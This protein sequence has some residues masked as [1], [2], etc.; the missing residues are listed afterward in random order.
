[1]NQRSVSL[2]HTR[3]DSD[4][5]LLFELYKNHEVKPK[6]INHNHAQQCLEILFHF[7]FRLGIFGSL[8]AS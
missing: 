3:I 6:C 5:K 2:V 8:C 4:V 1:M 7:V